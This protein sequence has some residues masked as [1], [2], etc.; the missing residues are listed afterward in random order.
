MSLGISRQAIQQQSQGASVIVNVPPPTGGWNTRDSLENMPPTDALVLDTLIPRL[1][2]VEAR[3]GYETFVTG[4]AATLSASGTAGWTGAPVQTLMS[5]VDGSTEYF[6]GAMDGGLFETR[7][8]TPAEVKS[9]GTYSSDYWEWTVFADSASPAAPKIIAVNGTDT[10]WT[11]DG[12]THANWAPTGPTA[13]NLAW[14]MSY[15]NRIYAGEVNSRDFWYGDLGAIPG[16]MHRF[17]LS[18]VRGAQ[19]NVLFMAT[20]TRDTGSG[21]DDFAV[22]VTDQGQAIVYTGTW[23]GGGTGTWE[24]VGVYQIPKPIPSRRAHVQL[25]GDVIIA[26]ELDYIFLSAAIQKSGALILDPSKLTG[27]MRIMAA[28]YKQVAE[29]SMHIDQK[30]SLI[31]SNIPLTADTLYYQH[32]FDAQTLSACRF[33]G[34]NFSSFGVFN[35]TL[36]GGGTDEIYITSSSLSDDATDTETRI[37]LDAQTAWTHFGSNNIKHV[38]AVRPVLRSQGDFTYGAGVGSDF[39]DAV[40]ATVESTGPTSAPTYWGDDPVNTPTTY[41]GDDPVNTPETYWSGTVTADL[42]LVREWRLIGDRGVE[43]SFSMKAQIKDQ[44]MD[45]LSTDYKVIQAGRF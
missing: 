7:T 40:V 1:G 11:Y 12:T 28:R 19:G 41:W 27:D 30:N 13:A 26:T 10:P 23:P 20:M 44:R 25:M 17:P 38:K 45:W 36:Y 33:T 24:L 35:G 14:V 15:K 3:K 37:N 31:I 2:R 16:T 18:G 6:V 22:F 4:I 39:Q 32:V 8:G 21:P 42:G 29:W 43:F 5:L 9:H 34:W